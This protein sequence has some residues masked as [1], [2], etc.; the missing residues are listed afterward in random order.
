MG[1]AELAEARPR[2]GESVRES[3]PRL[4]ELRGKLEETEEELRGLGYRT[5][6][7]V[8][9]PGSTVS[10]QVFDS[11]TLILL[12]FGELRVESG[13][14]ALELGAG[15]RLHVPSGV[16]YRVRV[17]GETAAYWIEA[18]RREEKGRSIP[19]FHDD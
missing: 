8:A 1:R 6:R 17:S 5:D 10:N 18:Q 9:Y 15:G 3:D 13:E 2:N 14:E 16:A 11:E 4:A 7:S 12:L 19:A